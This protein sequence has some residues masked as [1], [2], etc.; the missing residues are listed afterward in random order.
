M[1]ERREGGRER[2]WEGRN[3]G[4]EGWREGERTCEREGD[5]VMVDYG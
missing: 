3:G 4:M 5:A 1:E 2:Q